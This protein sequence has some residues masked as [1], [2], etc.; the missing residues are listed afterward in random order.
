M[1]VFKKRHNPSKPVLVMRETTE[2]SEALDAGTTKLVGTDRKSISNSVDLL[3]NN[4]AVYEKMS[5]AT[6]PYGDR[7]C[8]AIKFVE[9]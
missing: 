3:L 6:N 5:K 1:V 9:F 2:R 7:D 8:K 4:K